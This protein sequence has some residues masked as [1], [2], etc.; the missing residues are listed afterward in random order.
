[1]FKSRL[2]E[3]T[4]TLKSFVRIFPEKEAEEMASKEPL[5]V[6]CKHS[7]STEP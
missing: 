4:V 2:S 6:R 3:I 5:E 7:V 1:M